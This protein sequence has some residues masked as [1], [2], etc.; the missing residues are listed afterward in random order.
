[1]EDV[2]LAARGARGVPRAEP[3]DVTRKKS[4]RYMLIWGKS[5]QKL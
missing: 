5:G 2:D 1:M 4:G 3:R